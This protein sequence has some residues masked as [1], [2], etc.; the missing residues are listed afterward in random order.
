MRWF[1]WNNCR[2]FSSSCYAGRLGCFV[3]QADSFRLE[4][5][6][7]MPIWTMMKLPLHSLEGPLPWATRNARDLLFLLIIILSP[8]FSGMGVF[9]AIRLELFWVYTYVYYIALHLLKLL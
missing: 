6:A 4:F 3:L 2:L 5:Y 9:F 7:D 1:F 8:D